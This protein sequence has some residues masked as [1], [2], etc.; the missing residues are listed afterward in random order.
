MFILQLKLKKIR[1]F[2]YGKYKEKKYIFWKI[3]I[4][5]FTVIPMLIMFK[6]E[7]FE[8]LQNL[9]AMLNIIKIMY[10]LIIYVIISW[11]IT[12]VTK[13]SGISIDDRMFIVSKATLFSCIPYGNGRIKIYEPKGEVLHKF[14][15][16]DT[17]YLAEVSGVLNY[18][19][20]RNSIWESTVEEKIKRNIS[21]IKKNNRTILLIKN[22]DTFVG[23][24]HILP[25]DI[26]TWDMYL[27]GKIGDNDFSNDRIV[28]PDSNDI[29]GIIIFSIVYLATQDANIRID[30]VYQALTY[31]LYNFLQ[32]KK[33]LKILL[34]TSHS[35]FLAI[36]NDYELVKSK[37]LSKDK[38]EI[39]TGIIEKGII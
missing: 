23:Y 9:S 13:K 36:V 25:V 1:I 8:I 6:A 27:D 2:F 18:T 30:L 34:Q 33:E 21:H 37:K 20:F 31:H 32:K 19:G 24:T 35:G 14:Q 39:F 3:L 10:I 17:N 38:E 28:T 4:T 11:F 7:K 15:F 5:A 29:H 22:K 16:V 26:N 12:K